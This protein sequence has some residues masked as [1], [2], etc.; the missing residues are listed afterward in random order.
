MDI[1]PLRSGLRNHKCIFSTSYFDHLKKTER[2][3]TRVK[4]A[5]NEQQK[6]NAIFCKCKINHIDHE[7]THNRKNFIYFI[8]RTGNLM[9]R[10]FFITLNLGY[11][12]MSLNLEINNLE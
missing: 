8:L 11:I 2:R 1:V 4:F 6:E 5:A 10:K 3:L 12:N 9:I 7:S